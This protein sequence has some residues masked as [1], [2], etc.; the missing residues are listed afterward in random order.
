MHPAPPTVPGYLVLAAGDAG[1]TDAQAVRQVLEVLAAAAPTELRPTTGH[2]DLETALDDLAGRRLVVA[3][4]DGSVHLVV[5][6]LLARGEATS[7]PLGVVPLGT[8]ND[9]AQSVGLP[10]DPTR[11]AGRVVAGQVRALDVV[12]DNEY[13]VV[14]AA[15]AGFGVSAARHAQRLKPVLGVP[16][17]RPRRRPPGRA[18]RHG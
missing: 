8:G 1:S 18:R 16:A 10:L 2:Q 7:T 5:N 12:Q 3:G 14:N 4:G 13:V 17:G 9:L 15:H 11:A 6:A